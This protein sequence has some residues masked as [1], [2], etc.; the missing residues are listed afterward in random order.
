MRCRGLVWLLSLLMLMAAGGLVSCAPPDETP[1]DPVG[2]DP[3]ETEELFRGTLRVAWRD[4][5]STIDLHSTTHVSTRFVAKNIYEMLFAMNEEFQP[6][7][8]LAEDYS[9]SDDARTYTISLRQGVLFHNGKEMTSEDVLASVERW[10][11]MS[12]VGRT[13]FENI[14]SIEDLGPY[15]IRVQLV[16]PSFFFLSSMA[17]AR[18]GPVI[19]PK[20][21]VD[22]AG[23]DTTDQ[24][25]GTGPFMLDEW[26]HDREIRLVRFED[27]SPRGEEPDG[28]SGRRTAYVDEIV[29]TQV[30]DAAVRAMSLEAG[31]YDFVIDISGDDYARLRDNPDLTV[32]KSSPTLACMY[33]NKA[34]G[35]MADR[36]LRQAAL[37]ALNQ[38]EIMMGAYGDPEVYRLNPSIM[39]KETAYYT[40]VAGEAWNQ[41]DQELAKQLMEEAGYAGE[42][43]RWMAQAGSEY[44]DVAVITRDQMQAVGF[45]IDLEGLDGATLR[46]YRGDPT[47]YEAFFGGQ[48][49]RPHPINMS[50]LHSDWPGWWALPEKTE[51]KIQLLQS[52]TYEDEMRVWE[53]I[54]ELVYWDVP[55][56]KLGETYSLSVHTLD[57]EGYLGMPDPAFWNVRLL[58][59]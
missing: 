29:Y 42:T 26:I 21:V 44:Y 43:L 57:V 6:Q 39:Y 9:I 23:T 51:L 27:Y 3:D 11:Q 53:Q 20:E 32:H 38:D 54:Q 12:S 48:T 7:P 15:E 16:E 14:E 5:P 28:Y 34:E 33:I 17:V 24:V 22:A 47:M 19:Y 4:E 31:D 36:L 30:P 1:D 52:P 56:V 13:V 2:E 49:Y 10:G 55:I 41:H 50:W 45:N 46:E 18:Q 35:I 40:E 37:A 58:D 8:M 25:I 59:R